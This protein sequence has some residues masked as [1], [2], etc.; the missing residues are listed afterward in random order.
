MIQEESMSNM[1]QEDLGKDA[2]EKVEAALEFI[3]SKGQEVRILIASSGTKPLLKPMN[4]ARKPSTE[5]AAEEE[6]EPEAQ[7]KPTW[8]QLQHKI[9]TWKTSV[10]K[11]T[12]N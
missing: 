9:G 2:S 11:E 12:K 1:T 6:K 4:A 3:K 10:D 5:G 7:P 8:I